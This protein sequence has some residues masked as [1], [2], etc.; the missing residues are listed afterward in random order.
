MKS[1]FRPLIVF[2]FAI[3]VLIFGTSIPSANSQPAKAGSSTSYP[4]IVDGPAN[5]DSQLA[6]KVAKLAFQSK[7]AKS[8]NA[9]KEAHDR[10]KD[11]V[12]WPI[13]QGDIAFDTTQFDKSPEGGDSK[14]ICVQKEPVDGMRF[15]VRDKYFN[16]QGD[17]FNVLLVTSKDSSAEVIKKL[18][19]IE[20]GPQYLPIGYGAVI[21]DAWQRP[22]ILK[23]SGTGKFL[24]FDTKHPADF[25]SDW[26]VYAPTKDAKAKVIC[27]IRFKPPGE[28]ATALL[29]KGPLLQFAI[30]MNKIIGK[31][32]AN[33]GTMHATDRLRLDVQQMW[34]N[35][36]YRPWAM[37]EP[38]N[39]RA[40]VDKYLKRWAR[41]SVSYRKQ[42]ASVQAL[43]PQALTAL[44]QYYEQS[45]G[46]GHAEAQK[47]AA[48]N[49]DLAYRSHF[50]I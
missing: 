26:D 23:N 27:K 18:D 46:K 38:Q 44:T 30:L 6:L 36:L 34:A 20:T 11:L 19:R 13:D 32:R 49:L 8:F 1:K 25:M 39:S 2:S 35:V 42:F 33:E 4:C 48:K 31:P 15:V 29:P 37:A 17:W 45:L 41:G 47:M 43:Y 5:A 7:Q 28:N 3:A 50:T 16:W 24:A 9:G 22:W 21:R 40:Q 10:C 14:L 12:L